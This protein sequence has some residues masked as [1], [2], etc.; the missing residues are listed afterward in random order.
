MD[1]KEKHFRELKK[2][3]LPLPGGEERKRWCFVT[4]E[5]KTFL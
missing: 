1:E 4:V 5:K 3:T 2:I